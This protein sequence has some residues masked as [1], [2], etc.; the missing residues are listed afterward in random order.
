MANGVTNSHITFELQNLTLSEPYTTGGEEVAVGNDND[1]PITSIGSF[2]FINFF[3]SFHLKYVLNYPLV[4]FNVLSIQIFCKENY[5]WFALKSIFF[6]GRTISW[7]GFFYKGQ[8]RIVYIH[9]FPTSINKARS[10]I[11]L[12]GVTIDSCTWHYQLGHPT[13]FILSLV[14]SK[15]FVSIKGYVHH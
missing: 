11:A 13:S 7:S 15:S 2:V 12:L 6:F 14:K 1:L 4:A 9:Y 5:R 3:I 8:V 10:Y